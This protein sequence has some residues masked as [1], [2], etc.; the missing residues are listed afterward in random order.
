[1]TPSRLFPDPEF[2]ALPVTGLHERYPV[3]RIFCV[4]RNYAEHAKEMGVE[5]D[6]T[7]PF[8]FLK[9]P[10]ALV[11]S[12]ASVPYPPGTENYHHEMELVVA[13][14]KP[15]FRASPEEA[16]KSVCGFACGLDM[17]R[18]DLQ[19]AARSAGRP[20]DLGKDFEQSAV[21]AEIALAA[22][23]GPVGPQRISLDVNGTTRQSARL[24]DLV[25]SIDELL[26]DLSHYYHLVPGD[27]L[28]TGTP[29]GVGPVV[30]GDRLR[31][32]IDGLKPVELIIGARE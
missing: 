29:A 9:H 15:I 24:S 10:L 4:G 14:G 11:Q 8:Y 30:P 19:L 20:W 28:F 27:L 17:T 12:G 3:H 1:M 31:G 32:E 25:W 5:V 16:S 13:L 7:A 18:R 2:S 6:R 21:V 22:E 23:F 26:S